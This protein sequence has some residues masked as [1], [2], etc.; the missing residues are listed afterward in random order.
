M[1]TI[2][3]SSIVNDW[4]ATPDLDYYYNLY[5]IIGRLTDNLLAYMTM[6]DWFVWEPY[7]HVQDA[8]QKKDEYEKKALRRIFGDLIL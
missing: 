5:R 4:N 8:M 1:L 7:K 6:T 2:M 3:D